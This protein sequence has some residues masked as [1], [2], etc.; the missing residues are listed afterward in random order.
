MGNYESLRT[1]LTDAKLEDS[2]RI[3]QDVIDI[4]KTYKE[5][6]IS[7]SQACSAKNMNPLKTRFTVLNLYK[8]AGFNAPLELME[9]DMVYDGYENFYWAIFGNYAK[10]TVLPF[11]YKESVI[12]VLKNT[13][14]D[15]RESFVLMHHFGIVDTDLP[16]SLEAIGEQL[17]IVKNRVREIETNALRHCRSRDRIDILRY[18]ISKYA[19]MQKQAEEKHD[20]EMRHRQQTHEALM[21]KREADQES[22]MKDIEPKSYHDAL[23]ETLPGNLLTV[24]NNTH[25]E[26]LK[27]TIRAENTLLKN[28]IHTM[29]ELIP[30]CSVM[31]LKKLHGMGDVSAEDI[32]TKM[33]DYTQ[34]RFDT[35]MHKLREIVSV[36][37]VCDL[38]REP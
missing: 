1:Q 30:I 37:T 18:G 35:P 21:A 15:E 23:I 17:H 34:W 13:N 10:T 12:H 36:Q 7:W 32:V 38:H 14:L 4:C 16:Q 29:Y 28:K 8:C 11:D 19:A 20:Q 26:E 22:L 25:I 5:G 2:V 31:Q 33:N 24:L 3:L 6:N 27:L 9:P